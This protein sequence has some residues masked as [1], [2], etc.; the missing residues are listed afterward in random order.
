M[1]LLKVTLFIV[2]I[3]FVFSV[4]VFNNAI[5]FESMDTY[6]HMQANIVKKIYSFIPVCA[7]NFEYDDL[8]V[9]FFVDLPERK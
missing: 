5:I 3:Q 1:S 8:Y 6:W 2:H 7:R 4:H 9:E